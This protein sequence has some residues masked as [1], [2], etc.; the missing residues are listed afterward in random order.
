MSTRITEGQHLLSTLQSAFAKAIN[1][2][3]PEQQDQLRN[4]MAILRLSWEQLS[5]D[6]NTVQ[7]QIKSVFS[8][9]EDYSDA[10]S[11][12]EHWL[13]E[14]EDTL[15]VLPDT[16]G[17]F[18]EMKTLLERCKHLAEEVKN[19]GSDLDHLLTEAAEL[20]KWAKD[21]TT[22]KQTKLLESRW[23]ALGQQVE[24]QKKSVEEEVQD[25]NAYHSALQ[26]TEKWLLQISFQLM[27]HNS[28]YIT[29]KEQTVEQ[30]KQHENLL[31]EIQKYQLVLDDLK[32]KGHGQIERY[33]LVNPSIRPIIDTQLQNVR[34]SYN[35]L[36]NT[37]LQIKNRLAESFAKFQ[38]YE[39]T[40]ESIM[41]N[42]DAYEPEVAEELQAPLDT[43]ESAEESL[44]K[45][46]VLHNKLQSE[47]GRL[48]VAVEA[49]EAAAACLSRPGSPL[50]AP[51]VQIPAKEIEVRS[52]LEDLI[53][54]VFYNFAFECDRFLRAVLILYITLGSSCKILKI[55]IEF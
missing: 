53:D 14:T 48:A 11:R 10:H 31:E 38:E 23:E 34:E 45:A 4:D 41:Q 20:S 26:E 47:K 3:L 16:K 27:S 1:T 25:Y 52:R 21:D 49:C 28:L 36:L 54:Q 22:Q 15:K 8:R 19:K 44:E 50:D 37:A 30:M 55:L 43:L 6:L 39:N 7:A 32:A 51:P 18:G 46:R 24:E 5:I 35:S 42:L 40:L 33:E 9:W 12:F 17:E 29:N 2:A 13:S